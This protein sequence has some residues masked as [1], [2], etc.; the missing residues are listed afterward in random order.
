VPD[1]GPPVTQ[2]SSI[3][4]ATGEHPRAS[5]RSRSTTKLALVAL[6]LCASLLASTMLWRRSE[7]KARAAAVAK[8]TASPTTGPPALAS[9]A[10]PQPSTVATAPADAAAAPLPSPPASAGPVASA[11]AKPKATRP[12]T[13]KPA[14]AAAAADCATPFWFDEHEVKHYK[15]QCLYK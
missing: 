5:K 6:L 15:P 11:T 8:T 2:P 14:A 9:D 1:E 4:V 13:G 12:A 3:S 7:M 10:P